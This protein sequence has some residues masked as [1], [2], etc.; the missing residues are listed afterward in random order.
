M[1]RILRQNSQQE[2]SGIGVC[3]RDYCCHTAGIGLARIRA[4]AESHGRIRVNICQV[5]LGHREIKTH[6]FYCDQVKHRLPGVYPFP[7]FGKFGAHHPRKGRPQL[8]PQQNALPVAGI[9]LRPMQ[10]CFIAGNLGLN[11]PHHTFGNAALG[12]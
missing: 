8:V 10:V 4:Q 1:P 9:R 2:C 11:I 3:D 12:D 6:V 7:R 5:V